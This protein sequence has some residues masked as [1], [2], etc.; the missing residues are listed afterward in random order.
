MQSNGITAIC[1]LRVGVA[2]TGVNSQVT[3]SN[4]EDRLHQTVPR[5]AES[6][7]WITDANKD[8]DPNQL[9]AEWCESRPI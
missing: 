2:T 9:A 7:T 1:D 8:A 5:L 4:A 3:D 6:P